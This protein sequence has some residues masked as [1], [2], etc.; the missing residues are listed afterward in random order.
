MVQDNL[1]GS[2]LGNI[3]DRNTYVCIYVYTTRVVG[4]KID[5]ITKWRMG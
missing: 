5:D 4:G 1:L 3:I 2:W